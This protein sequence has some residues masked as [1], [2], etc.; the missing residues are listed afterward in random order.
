MFLNLSVRICEG[1]IEIFAV[2]W[3]PIAEARNIVGLLFSHL[4]LDNFKI[5]VNQAIP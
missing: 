3:K 2:V 1:S 4:S 5:A